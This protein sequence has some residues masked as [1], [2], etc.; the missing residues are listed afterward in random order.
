V[1]GVK[2]PNH[3][4]TSALEDYSAQRVGQLAMLSGY[5]C[6]KD[7][8]SCGMQRVKV[9]PDGGGQPLRKGQGVFTRTL[10]TTFPLLP[11][12]EEGRLNDAVLRENF[13]NRVFVYHEWQHLKRAGLQA[14]ALIDFHARC[15]YLLMAHSQAAYKRLGRLLANLKNTDLNDI[16][17]AYITELMTALKR[18]VTPKR[19]VN[20]LQHIMGY[21]K[22][23]ID[24]GDKAELLSA[25]EAYRRGETPLVVPITLLKHYFRRHPDAYIQRQI[26]LQPHPEHLGLRNLL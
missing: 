4:V 22:K 16:A 25:I 26:Y 5:L 12:E 23:Q 9:Y 6:K 15:K 8:P 19:H 17:T 11:V 2:D 14:E 13:V 21:L 3:E 20:V 7:S 18:P 24:A 1:V 10:M